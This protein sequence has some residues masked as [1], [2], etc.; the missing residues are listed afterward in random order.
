MQLPVL[1]VDPRLS[2]QLG[3]R[4]CKS[5]SRYSLCV[6]TFTNTNTE[7]KSDANTYT[8]TDGTFFNSKLQTDP[9]PELGERV[10]RFQAGVLSLS[11]LLKILPLRILD[12]ADFAS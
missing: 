9:C 12:R 5:S 7:K 8:N 1:D 3:E 10:A 4:G 11:V 2:L 6:F